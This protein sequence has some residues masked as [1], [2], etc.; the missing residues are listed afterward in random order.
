MEDR[1]LRRGGR[2]DPDLRHR[3]DEAAAHEISPCAGDEVARRQ[4]CEEV[5]NE[6]AAFRGP[7]DGTPAAKPL[8]RSTHHGGTITAPGS[9][10]V[11]T[12][13]FPGQASGMMRAW[14]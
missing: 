3:A 9:Q 11:T 13:T 14:P 6:P 2:S 8:A 5:V 7:L 12:I 10:S 1:H 4:T